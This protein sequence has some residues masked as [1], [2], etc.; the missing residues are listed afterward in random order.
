MVILL[1]RETKQKVN[2]F[3]YFGLRRTPRVVIVDCKG[4]G[5]GG[6]TGKKV[7]LEETTSDYMGRCYTERTTF[8]KL[9]N[10]RWNLLRCNNF[11]RDIVQYQPTYYKKKG[12]N[13]LFCSGLWVK[14]TL[15]FTA[16]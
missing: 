6:S 3:Q 7:H 4:K 1:R 16:E 13:N 2:P 9:G 8:I 5:K 11:P 14:V 10:H 15:H 12:Q